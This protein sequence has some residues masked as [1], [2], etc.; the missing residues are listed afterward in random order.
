[1]DE[2]L[3]PPR[4]LPKLR[5]P[6]LNVAL[7]LLTLA[8]TIVAGYTWF[9]PQGGTFSLGAVVAAGLPFAA[10][11]LSI[12][13]CH[14]MGHFVVARLHG[15]DSTLPFF[16]PVPLVGV[17]TFGAV[18]RLRSPLPSRRAVLDIGA[19]GPLAGFAVAL[20]LLLWGLAHSEIHQVA[21]GAAA[22]GIA[23]PFDLARLVARGLAG[24]RS[25][26]AVLRDLAQADHGAVVTMGDSLLTWAAQRVVVGPLAPGQDLLI[27]PVGFAAWIGLLVT[28]LNLVPFGQLDGGHVAYAL[29]GRGRALRLSRFVSAALLLFGLFGSWSWLVWWGLTRFVIRA[30][31]PPALRED[32]LDARH[33]AVAIL[34]LALFV[35][36]FLPRPIS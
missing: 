4:P 25:L 14:E 31:H 11:L 23:S 32:P 18:I 13:L 34:T 1:M 8:T 22:A 16:I 3:A 27:H 10:S 7:F 5:I 9:P 33:R 19:A 35:V 29:L 2:V 36:T 28:T 21:P 17:G 20:P 6:A 12:L 30:P 24:H 26:E 15:V